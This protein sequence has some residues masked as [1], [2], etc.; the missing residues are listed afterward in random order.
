MSEIYWREFD[1]QEE[2]PVDGDAVQGYVMVL[3]DLDKFKKDARETVFRPPQKE[4]ELWNT[5]AARHWGKNSDWVLAWSP[6]PA[7]YCLHCGR[8]PTPVRKTE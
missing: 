3:I 7:G 8:G 1:G 4:I 5:T 2:G 6:I